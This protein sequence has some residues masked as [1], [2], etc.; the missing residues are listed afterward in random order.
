MFQSELP[1]NKHID[2]FADATPK[3]YL[4]SVK[5]S[6]TGEVEDGLEFK[7]KGITLN[8]RNQKVING[9]EVLCTILEFPDHQL[10]VANPAKICREKKTGR[11]YTRPECK[12]WKLNCDKRIVDWDTFE[13]YPWGFQE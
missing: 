5:D 3:C 9:R 10:T 1:P 11:L 6:I 4:Y 12:T 7:V 2:F 8:C 13:T